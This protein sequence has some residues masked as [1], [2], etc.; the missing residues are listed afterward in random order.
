MMCPPQVGFQVCDEQ[1]S[2]IFLC[3]QGGEGTDSSNAAMQIGCDWLDLHTGIVELN[4]LDVQRLR[5]Q[6]VDV[7]DIKL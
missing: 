4:L 1:H 5:R 3:W 2:L 7:L 6:V